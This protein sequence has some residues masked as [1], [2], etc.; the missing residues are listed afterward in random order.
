MCHG[1]LNVTQGVTLFVI[2]HH[3]V[4]DPDI[5]FHAVLAILLVDELHPVLITWRKGV[6]TCTFVVIAIIVARC[7]I[8]LYL[9]LLSSS[10]WGGSII[11]RGIFDSLYSIYIT[12]N[13]CQIFDILYRDKG[14]IVF[15]F[16]WFQRLVTT[17]CRG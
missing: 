3:V 6:H 2:E 9:C 16:F 5:L 4:Y 11:I 15:F 12:V 14:I 7:S 8:L 10:R 17:A 1:C 13:Y